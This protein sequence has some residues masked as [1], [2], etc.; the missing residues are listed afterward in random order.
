MRTTLNG[1]TIA[2]SKR[3]ML[4]IESRG[5]LDYYFYFPIEDVRLDLL[6]ESDDVET[7]G[8]RG[9]RKLLTPSKARVTS[10][11]WWMESR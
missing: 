3:A 4:M 6:E 7:S 8:Y 5:E 11:S 2:D 9:S 10:R 1:E